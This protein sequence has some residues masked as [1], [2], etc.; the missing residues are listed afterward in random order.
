MSS[1]ESLRTKVADTR[2]AA[3]T[4]EE[5]V[6]Q[7]EAEN[8]R[9]RAKVAKLRKLV[10]DGTQ[11]SDDGAL[12]A[13]TAAAKKGPSNEHLLAT[14]ADFDALNADGKPPLVVL[15]GR[16]RCGRCAAFRPE[17]AELL[18][19]QPKAEFAYLNC[20]QKSFFLDL[21]V[22]GS[23][24]LPLL[25]FFDKGSRKR[26]IQP[27]AGWSP[28]KYAE[29]ATAILA[30]VIGGVSQAQPAKATKSACA[31]DLIKVA[32]D[33]HNAA[34]TSH[35]AASL[36][37]DEQC[38]V[39]AK[40]WAEH[41]A[42]KGKMYHG[43]HKGMGQNLAWSSGSLSFASAVEMWYG[44]VKL[45]DFAKPGFAS[46]TG[47]FTQ[48]VW[49]GTTHVGM[50]AATSASGQTYIC[51][52]Y[53]PPGN[54][55]GRFAENVLPKGGVPPS[56]LMPV[57]SLRK[58]PSGTLDEAA[59]AAR[60]QSAHRGKVERDKSNKLLSQHSDG[61]EA[62][63]KCKGGAD[64]LPAD[65]VALLSKMPAGVAGIIKKKIAEAP[66]T[67]ECELSMPAAVGGAKLRCSS[68]NGNT[69]TNVRW[70]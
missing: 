56:G 49:K 13:G 19:A 68:G 15:Y 18:Q 3:G 10:P 54:F 34:R 2:D 61:A 5:R 53:S 52:N 25:I 63:A 45:Y 48:V 47:H 39:T 32:L 55:M 27:K 60:M 12:S 17:W 42:A 57:P 14:K 69:T 62:A 8:G 7:L 11:V 1:P 9:L 31:L 67:A 24:G 46:G 22:S 70:G 36:E 51:A 44:E 4:L 30:D 65:V 35:G 21:G 50:A 43:G 37:W 66:A 28:A 59:A 20:D 40:E 29:E 6:K 23:I 38:Y 64:P 16:E 58:Q 33:K 26:T 41:M